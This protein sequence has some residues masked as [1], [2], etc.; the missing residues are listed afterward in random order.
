MRSYRIEVGHQHGVKP[1]NIVG[2]IANEA[3]IESKHIG[4]IEIY[5]DFSVLD[6]PAD[7]PKD[8]MQHLKAVWVAGQQLK[9][10]PDDHGEP[11]AEVPAARP[12]RPAKAAELPPPDVVE[13][14]APAKPKKDKRSDKDNAKSKFAVQSYR[15]EVGRQHN[16]TASAIVA[17]IAEQAHLEA[18]HVGRIDIHDNYSVL[19]LP[20]GMPMRIMEALKS[21]RLAGQRLNISHV[22]AGLINTD[23]PAHPAKNDKAG[24]PGKKPAPRGR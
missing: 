17:A 3:N 12:K 7:L 5:D 15:I 11:V 16:V 23:P 6:L 22:G 14:V 4:R 18:K 19:D 1:G 13:A 8:V 10:R 24:K 20:E 2:A 9:I 21:A